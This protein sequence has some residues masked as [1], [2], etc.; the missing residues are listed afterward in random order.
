M[1]VAALDLGSNT[2]LMLIAEVEHGKVNKVFNDELRVTRLGQG[3]H[4]NRALHPDALLRAEECFRDYAEILKHSKP[5]KILAMATSAARDVSNGQKLFDLGQKY[6]IP[7]RI[8]PGNLEAQITFEGAT[9][10]VENASGVCVVDVG[11]GST[12]VIA[13]SAEGKLVGQSVDIGSV[14]LTEMFVTS[15][16]VLKK[17]REEL[18]QYAYSQIKNSQVKNLKGLAKK[19]IAVA[20]TPTTLAAV[21]QEKSYSD[22]LVHGYVLSKKDLL[23]WEEKLANMPLAERKALAGMDPLRADVIIAGINI[24]LACLDFLGLKEL[25]VS[26]RGVRYGVALMA[27]K[28]GDI[29]AGPY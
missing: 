23:H 28:E 7:I 19:V 29:Y 14:R 20:G 18:Y 3:V 13:K 12:E 6:G 8:I 2:F 1:K 22:G 25:T 21:V 16:P 24:L 17:E 27:E 10:D 4:A 11:G 26:T 5:Q 9:F 15:H